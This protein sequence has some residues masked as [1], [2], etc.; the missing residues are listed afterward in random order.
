MQD[1]L[2]FGYG[3]GQ[4][5]YHS[6]YGGLYGDRFYPGKFARM[7]ARISSTDAGGGLACDAKPPEI[8]NERQLNRAYMFRNG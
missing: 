4:C 3:S 5:G 2:H 7:V 8:V 6:G 1:A